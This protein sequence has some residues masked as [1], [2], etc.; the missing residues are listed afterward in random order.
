MAKKSS[1]AGIFALATGLIA[2][3]AAVFFSNKENRKMVKKELTKVEKE[4]ERI[5]KE[6]QKD[7]KKF[8]KKVQSNTLKL[9]NKVAKEVKK[10]SKAVL[11]TEQ[12]LI[13][14]VISSPALRVVG[15]KVSKKK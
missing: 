6:V 3:A 1:G 5:T 13:K 12:K 11:K 4:A 7:P 8:A 14:K 15:K 10:D 2:G 9:A